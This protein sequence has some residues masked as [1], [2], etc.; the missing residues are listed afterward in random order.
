MKLARPAATIDCGNS[1][2]TMRLLAGVLAGQR[3]ESRLA[4]DASLSRRP[5]RRV[6]DPLTAMG[7]VAAAEGANGCAPLR[8]GGGG[9]RLRAIDFAMPVASAQVKSAVLLAGLS[10]EGVTSVTEPAPTRD[11]TERLLAHFGV[12]TSRAGPRVS[13]RGG[14][15]PV[16]RDLRVPGDISSAAFWAVAAAAQPGAEVVLPG[17]GLN[18]TRT[19]VL[20]VLRRMG[21]TVH[22]A[23]DPATGDGGE[24]AGTVTVTGSALHGTTIAGDEI[25]NVIDELPVLAVAG[26]LAAGTT[27]IRDAAELR[28]KESDR[29]RCVAENL[30]AMGVNVREFDDGM[31]I[32]GGLPLRGAE[33]DSHGDHRIA[34]AFAVAGLFAAGE[35][36]IDDVACIAT[37]YPGFDADLDRAARGGLRRPAA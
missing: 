21:A 5:M 17:V 15:V 31:E 4:G 24:P 12:E 25:A 29:I 22:E 36:R 33:I 20:G 35:T 10:A 28:V 7:G 6:I 8:L 11:H 3:F 13:L 9:A 26:A 34:M 27:V 37:S 32:G 16:A 18:P 23:H 14:Q 2:T 1:G 19:G 30:R